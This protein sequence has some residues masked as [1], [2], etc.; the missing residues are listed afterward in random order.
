MV[1]DDPSD[2]APSPTSQDLSQ[3]FDFGPEQTVWDE[4]DGLFDSEEIVVG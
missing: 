2:T 1:N 3:D 4:E